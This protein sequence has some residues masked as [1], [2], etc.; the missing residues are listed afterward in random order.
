MKKITLIIIALFLVSCETPQFVKDGASKYRKS[1]EYKNKSHKVL[2][3]EKLL[4]K[5]QE[6]ICVAEDL[7]YDAQSYCYNKENTI[8]FYTTYRQINAKYKIL[9]KRE[10]STNRVNTQLLPN[11]KIARLEMWVVKK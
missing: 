2:N 1:K 11:N 7:S 8:R 6:V 9:H 5:G 3:N 10:V 4:R